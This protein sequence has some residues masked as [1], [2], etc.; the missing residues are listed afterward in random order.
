MRRSQAQE[1]RAASTVG[2]RRHPGSG[3]QRFAKNDASNRRADPFQ[4][5]IEC[6]GRASDTAKQITIKLKDL[7]DV[8]RNAGINGKNPAMHLEIHGRDY[9]MLPQWVVSDLL[10][11]VKDLRE[12]LNA[13]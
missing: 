2:A 5:H 1:E 8:E 9:W 10:Q 6:K 7:D 11:L 13:V 3:N 12:E 4:F